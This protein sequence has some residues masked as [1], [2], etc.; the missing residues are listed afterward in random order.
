MT[1]RAIYENGVF[2]P[3]EKVDLP[4]K[5][6]VVFEPRLVQ[7]ADPP[8]GA[9]ARIYEILSRRYNTNQPDLAE[10]HNEHQP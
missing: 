1:V 10:R 7:K 2:K 6:E 4:E 9:M 5:A 8:T 3:S